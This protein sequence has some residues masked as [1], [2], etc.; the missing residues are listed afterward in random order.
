[1]FTYQNELISHVVK[2]TPKTIAGLIIASLM[3]LYLNKEYAPLNILLTW[4][5]LQTLF[6]YL[7]YANANNLKNSLEQNNKVQLY[8]HTK[9]LLGSLV[10]STLVWNFAFFITIFYTQEN[11]EFIAFIMTVGITTASV[12]S[13]SAM[14]ALFMIYFILMFTPMILF[15]FYLGGNEH[16]TLLM[17]T[18][19]FIP[20]ILVLSR[21]VHNYIINSTKTNKLLKQKIG[22]LHQLSIT[23]PLTNLYNRRYFFEITKNVLQL[24]KRNN[25]SDAFLMIDIDFFKKINDTHGHQ[26]GDFILKN[27]SKYLKSFVRSSDILARLGGEEF[28]LFLHNISVNDARRIAQNICSSISQEKFLYNNISIQI[29]L[30]IGLATFKEKIGTI[31]TLYEEADQNLYLAKT[32]GR[33]RVV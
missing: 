14:Y 3:F 27:L 11:F 10:Y 30:S 18:A 2:E 16:L 25:T 13:L 12:V 15:M 9:I 20:T 23:D 17:Y 31:D 24:S 21:S 19:I 6:I 5:L 32:T 8:K 7:R 4:T 26:A 33:N 22:E 28:G 29:T 1:M